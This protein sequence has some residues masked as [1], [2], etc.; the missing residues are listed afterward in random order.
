MS[1]ELRVLEQTE[2]DDVSGGFICGGFCVLGAIVA[3][4][5]LF[6]TGASIGGSLYHATR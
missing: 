1:S 3:G 2:I 5:G 6:A 4:V